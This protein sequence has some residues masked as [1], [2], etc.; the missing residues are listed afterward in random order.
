MSRS[1]ASFIIHEHEHYRFTDTNGKRVSADNGN[2]YIIGEVDALDLTTLYPDTANTFNDVP[3]AYRPATRAHI[4]SGNYRIVRK[5]GE[6]Y[7]LATNKDKQ[8]YPLT[9]DGRKLV[10]LIADAM[11]TAA[12]NV[13]RENGI[14]GLHVTYT[15]EMDWSTKSNGV[16]KGASDGM[17]RK[18]RHGRNDKANAQA[19]KAARAEKRAASRKSTAK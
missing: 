12:A 19:A 3:W 8:P 11:E 18:N 15:P 13:C 5:N 10:Q 4:K 16:R 9:L 14:H 2:T 1:D 6:T 7:T 17:N